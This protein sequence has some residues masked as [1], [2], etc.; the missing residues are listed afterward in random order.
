MISTANAFLSCLV[1]QIPRG[2]NT[3]ITF[4]QFLDRFPAAAGKGKLHYRFRSDDSTCGFVWLDM[5]DRNEVVPTSSG[6]MTCKILCLENTTVSKRYTRLRLK[7][8]LNKGEEGAAVAM[9]KRLTSERKVNV[10]NNVDRESRNDNGTG[11]QNI[12]QQRYSDNDTTNDHDHEYVEE[13]SHED[14][15]DEYQQAPAPTP[16]HSNVPAQTRNN[17]APVPGPRNSS[18]NKQ[19]NG[20]GTSGSAVKKPNTTA[21]V[22]NLLDNDESNIIDDESNKN[23]KNKATTQTPTPTPVIKISRPPVSA[24]SPFNVSSVSVAASVSTVVEQEQ[25]MFHFEGN[26]T[27]S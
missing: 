11:K 9:A 6:V 10:H 23:N 15:E 12:R 5:I 8:N 18:S 13:D 24:T 17:T 3:S 2:S 22:N 20:S 26:F 21:T 4:G 19:E 16:V 1:P 7:S 14:D 25:D 27:D